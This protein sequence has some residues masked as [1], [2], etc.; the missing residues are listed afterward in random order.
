MRSS[1]GHYRFKQQGSA[2]EA[3]RPVLGNGGIDL[4]LRSDGSFV[5]VSE[6]G[7]LP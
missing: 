4:P 7:P 2:E 3:M 5:P 1:N 6:R